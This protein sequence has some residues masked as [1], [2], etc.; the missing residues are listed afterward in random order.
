LIQKA[1]RIN[2]IFPARY[3]SALGQAYYFLGRYE[4][5][6]T[7]LREAT[8][9]NPNLL[10][11]RIYLIATLA[12][13]GKTDEAGWEADQLRLLAPTFGIQNISNMFPIENQ[14]I[15]RDIIYQLRRSGFG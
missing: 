6:N 3:Q 14:D 15:L 10:P 12:K 5:A 9:R 7:A 8:E 1:I 2:P 11:S 13:L 4:N